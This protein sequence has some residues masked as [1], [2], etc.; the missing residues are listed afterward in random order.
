MNRYHSA[1]KERKISAK[2]KRPS[3]A[4]GSAPAGKDKPAFPSAHV[5]GKTQSKDRSGGTPKCKVYPKSE[6]L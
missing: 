1:F 6:G 5:P 2:G 3:H 4:A